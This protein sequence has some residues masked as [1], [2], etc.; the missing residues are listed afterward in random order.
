VHGIAEKETLFDA[1]FPQAFI[2]LGRDIDQL[3]SLAGLKPEFFPIAFHGLRI[4]EVFRIGLVIWLLVLVFKLSHDIVSI[5]HSF[6]HSII[7]KRRAQ[8]NEQPY[9]LFA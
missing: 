8:N 9:A 7:D 3:P 5:I 4:F 2:Q 1:A 6:Y